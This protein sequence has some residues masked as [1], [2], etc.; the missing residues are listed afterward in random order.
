MGLRGFGRL[1]HFRAPPESL[2]CTTKKGGIQMQTNLPPGQIKIVSAIRELSERGQKPT[3][4]ELADFIGLRAITGVRSH[5][6]RLEAKGIV[7]PRRPRERRA[8]ELTE[9][10]A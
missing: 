10:Y 6:L 7:K 8:I 4:Q 2:F 9:A 1:T 3:L 5:L